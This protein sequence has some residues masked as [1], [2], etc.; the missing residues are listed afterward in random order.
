MNF[1]SDRR[2]SIKVCREPLSIKLVLTFGIFSSNV[3]SE[4][5]RVLFVGFSIKASPSTNP[6]FNT[7]RVTRGEKCVLKGFRFL[8]CVFTSRKKWN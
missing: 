7:W 1:I 6:V 3:V 2:F 4:E 5:L 8:I